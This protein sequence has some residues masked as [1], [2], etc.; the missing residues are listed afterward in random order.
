[1][2]V[3]GQLRLPTSWGLALQTRVAGVAVAEHACVRRLT[4]RTERC[5][6]AHGPPP[7]PRDVG[8]QRL[9]RSPRSQGHATQRWPGG[10]RTWADPAPPAARTDSRQVTERVT[11]AGG[12][13]LVASRGGGAATLWGGPGC[14][15]L[16][17]AS[18][19]DTTGSR[20]ARREGPGRPSS[21]TRGRHTG[22]PRGQ[23]LRQA[24]PSSSR[25]PVSQELHPTKLSG[26]WG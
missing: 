6:D 25:S 7:P 12:W 10:L 23:R 26:R 24:D 3:F 15:A 11:P 17:E 16:P 20:S 18:P 9:G 8:K 4:L 1:M 19:G 14:T 21:V 2:R 13:G 22:S 5:G